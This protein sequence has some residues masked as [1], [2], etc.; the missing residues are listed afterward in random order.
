MN[1]ITMGFQ[2]AALYN[3]FIILFSKGF[4]TDL[5]AIDPLFSPEGSF[6]ILLWGAAYLALSRRYESAPGIA[7]VFCVEKAFY[8]FHWLFWIMGHQ[9][10]IGV[11]FPNDPLTAVFFAI[12]GIGDLLFMI[13]F[14]WVAWKWRHNITGQI[15]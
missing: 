7:L 11:I 8:G 6:C 10:D 12:Y 5:G 1:R 4:S 14:A 9:Q 3:F 2:I 15:K 13:F